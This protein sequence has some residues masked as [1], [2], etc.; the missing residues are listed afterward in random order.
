MSCDCLCRCLFKFIPLCYLFCANF[1]LQ[2]SFDYKRIHLNVLDIT[3]CFCNT[4]IHQN[5]I[6]VCAFL[7]NA[8]HV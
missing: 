3:V 5:T 4:M 7:F 2:I 8:L 1:Y 6:Q